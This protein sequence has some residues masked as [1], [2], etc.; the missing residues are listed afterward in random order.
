MESKYAEWI[1]NNVEG[2]GYG[3]CSEITREMAEAFPELSRVCGL[4]LCFM[5]GERQ[6]WWLTDKEGSVVDPTAAQF[7]SKGAGHYH[8]MTPEE[9]ENEIPI[10]S[11]ANCGD[12]IYRNNK[13]GTTVCSDRCGA[14]YAAYC[15]SPF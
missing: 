12:P 5:W 13:C 3:K 2:D 7:P 10:A 4:Y 1:E 14:E 9:I 11:C 8:Q 15:S 6:H